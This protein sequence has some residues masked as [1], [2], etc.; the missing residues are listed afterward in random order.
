MAIP[1]IEFQVRGHTKMVRQVILIETSGFEI[2]FTNS[3]NQMFNS[4]F[5]QERRRILG[6]DLYQMKAMIF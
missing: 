6:L 3:N 5:V 1:V 4:N 2:Y